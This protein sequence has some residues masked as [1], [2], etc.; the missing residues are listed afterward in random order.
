MSVGARRRDILGQ[1]LFEALALGVAG[2]SIG[3][4]VGLGVPYLAKWLVRGVEVRNSILSAVLAFL[5]SCVVA[6]VFGAVPAYRASL[7][8]PTEALHHE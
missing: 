6:V 4:A 7:L 8:N 2:A 3:V 5:F 1:F